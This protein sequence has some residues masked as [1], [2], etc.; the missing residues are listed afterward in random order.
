MAATKLG[1]TRETVNLGHT[2]KL[3][4]LSSAT[5]CLC[6]KENE[7]LKFLN[8]DYELGGRAGAEALHGKRPYAPRRCSYRAHSVACIN[9]DFNNLCFIHMSLPVTGVELQ[10]LLA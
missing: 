6:A 2:I 3:L 1:D 4:S 9:Q 5:H 10:S 8:Y 7:V